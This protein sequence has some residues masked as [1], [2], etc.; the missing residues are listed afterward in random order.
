MFNSAVSANLGFVLLWVGPCALII[1]GVGYYL[2][3][4]R[5][6]QE[7]D[8]TLKALLVLLQSTDQ[9]STDVEDRNTE[10]EDVGRAVSDLEATGKSGEIRS[11]LL[12]QIESVVTSNKKLE[13]DL[14]CARYSLEQQAEELD[15]TRREARLD[16]LSGVSN[17]RSFDETLHYWLKHYVQQD[18]SFGLVLADIDHFKRIND[19]HGHQAGDCVVVNVGRT[20]L[21]CLRGEDYVARYGGDEFAMLLRHAKKTSAE[22]VAERIRQSVERLSFKPGSGEERVSVTFSMGL[23]IAQEDDS[24]EDLLKRADASLFDAKKAGRNCLC[25]DKRARAVQ[26]SPVAVNA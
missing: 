12:D 13:H 17:R 22:S 4:I 9:L 6:R 15:R 20:L 7:R 5:S 18:E 25:S 26:E 21:E 3:R 23:A 24:A 2:G 8:T 10:L 1:L 16:P 11:T 19:T 14:Y